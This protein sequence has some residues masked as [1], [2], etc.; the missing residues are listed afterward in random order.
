MVAKPPDH[1]AHHYPRLSGD[2]LVLDPS[3]SGRFQP[4]TGPS[5]QSER[6]SQA[7]IRLI[8]CGTNDRGIEGGAFRLHRHQESD[9][10]SM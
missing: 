6:R 5:G 4:V 9:M 3:S 2:D 8:E 10:I 7:L 1:G